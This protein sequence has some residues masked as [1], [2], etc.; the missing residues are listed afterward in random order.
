MTAR[1][2]LPMPPELARIAA[3]I[4]DTLRGYDKAIASVDAEIDFLRAERHRLAHRR[5]HVQQHGVDEAAAA[6]RRRAGES[7]SILA[8]GMTARL[9]GSD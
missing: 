8:P 4:D 6:A 7:L 2:I 3:A 1:V 9:D 5:Q